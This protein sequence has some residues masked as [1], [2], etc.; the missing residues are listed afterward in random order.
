MY[1]QAIKV[2][3]EYA[4]GKSRINSSI[5][6][7]VSGPD[8][9]VEYPAKR[10]GIPKTGATSGEQNRNDLLLCSGHVSSCFQMY[11]NED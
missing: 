7:R 11:I 2:Y 3:H 1:R 9:D 8:E 6:L 5:S 10:S 4:S